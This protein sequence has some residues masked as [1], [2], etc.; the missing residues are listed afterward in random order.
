[1]YIYVPG[2]RWGVFTDDLRLQAR[3]YDT[4]RTFRTQ[5]K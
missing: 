3:S 1:M 5:E 4:F 2:V